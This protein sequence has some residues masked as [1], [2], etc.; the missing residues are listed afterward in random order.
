[1]AYKVY[2]IPAGP[3]N[4]Q[5]LFPD[6]NWSEVS[7]YQLQIGQNLDVIATTPKFTV[8]CCCGDEEGFVRIKFL[9]YAGMY[10]SINLSIVK[11]T[12]KTKSSDYTKSLPYNGNIEDFESERYNIISNKVFD[13]ISTCYDIKSENWLNELID[14]P[15]A[16]MQWRNNYW[17]PIKILDG[18]FEKIQ[19]YNYQL[20]IQFTLSSDFKI[21]RN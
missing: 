2:Y 4:L 14:T 20:K 21:I 17:L 11:T 5:N 10:D 7:S 13:A 8:G 19:D 12:K 1:M 15:K 6:I 9:T 16:Y 18:T 3:K